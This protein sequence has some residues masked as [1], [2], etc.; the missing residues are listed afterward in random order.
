MLKKFKKYFMAQFYC[1]LAIRRSAF[2]PFDAVSLLT[3]ARARL[4]SRAAFISIFAAIFSLSLL[5]CSKKL[6][7]EEIQAKKQEEIQKAKDQALSNY[8]EAL[9]D[10][11]KICQLF[12]VN[13]GGR[14]S[15]V[16]SEKS[17]ILYGKEEEGEALLPGGV[18]LF[19][20]NISRDPLEAHDFIKSIRDF[21][22][23]EGKTPPYISVDQEGGLV[24]RFRGL[25]SPFWSQKEVSEK[26]S[27]EGARLLYSAQA[28]QLKCLG[29]HMNIAPVVE[30]ENDSNREFLVS[31]TFGSLQN[32]K[33]YGK[34]A[35]QAFEDLGIATVLK[36]FP[37]NSSTDPHTGLPEIKVTS[38]KL[39][40]EY[41][42]PFREL[43]PCSSALLMS[44][45]RISLEDDSSY[46]EAKTPACLSRYWV[47]DVV[48]NKLGFSSLILSDDI[49][50]GALSENGFPPQEAAVKA[51]KA[52]IDIIM[53]TEKRFGEVAG[54]LLAKTK[55]DPDFASEV[56]RA[57]TNI[58]RYKIK[59]GI[60]I[61][62]ETKAEGQSEKESSPSF[63]IKVN[64][65]YPDFDLKAFNDAY[66]DGMKAF[67]N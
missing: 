58:L 21:Y 23:K 13:V 46:T 25:T 37:G 35:I 67:D 59:A 31:R 32:V 56:K 10:E 65:S 45:A 63:T 41:F 8:I 20:Y 57:V 7:P 14:E 17:G 9:S 38:E 34:I 64:D 51:I 33:D 60:L 1:Q 22:L 19:T 47:S 39:E 6:S 24:N 62:E 4:L 18:I 49:F 43:L 26:F 29:F 53:L 54:S 12:L 44:H 11:E 15:Y 52:G 48:K 66:N 5:S 2:A 40:S 36:H 61:L 28:R 27:L 3:N 55:E 16:P 30:V 50:M 42:A